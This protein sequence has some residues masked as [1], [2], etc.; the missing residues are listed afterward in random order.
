MYERKDVIWNDI[1]D[2][3][4]QLVRS[5]F[6]V[7]CQVKP[8]LLSRRYFVIVVLLKMNILWWLINLKF[9]QRNNGYQLRLVAECQCDI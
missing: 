3:R 6:N 8:A 2:E 5:L 1:H 9:R 7:H 4:C